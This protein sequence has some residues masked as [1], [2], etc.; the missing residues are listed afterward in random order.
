M[1]L[2]HAPMRVLAESIPSWDSVFLLAESSD[3]VL[4]L[5]GLFVD[6][7]LASFEVY[8]ERG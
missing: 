7:L 2:T 6:G 1:V 3:V 8:L 4:L 5:V